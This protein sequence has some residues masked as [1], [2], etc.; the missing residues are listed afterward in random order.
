M[1]EI[2]RFNIS[3]TAPVDAETTTL[4]NSVTTYGAS[5]LP[6]TGISRLQ[7]TVEN[8]HSGTLKLYR[9]TNGGTNWDQAAGG[10]LAVAA[11][12]ATDVS[13][14]YDYL[15]DAYVDVKLDWV[16]GGTTQTTWRPSL[17][18]VV[19]DRAKGT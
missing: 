2:I 14:P 16:N 15:I 10:D 3:T 8:S 12:G 6:L 11:A 1:S 5:V 19:G 13:G 18:A 4:F 9:S 17:T 7:F